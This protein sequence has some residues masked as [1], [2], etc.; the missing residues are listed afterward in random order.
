MQ[1][2]KAA[3]ALQAC[4]Y[5]V[6]VPPC[7]TFVRYPN[8]KPQ[9][10]DGNRMVGREVLDPMPCLGPTPPQSVPVAKIPASQGW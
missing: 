9:N 1:T 10:I 4:E 7:V 5:A 6:A 8:W 2:I 3:Y